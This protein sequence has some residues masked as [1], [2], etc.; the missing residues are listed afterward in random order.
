MKEEGVSL[1]TAVKL[2]DSSCKGPFQGIYGDSI[3]VYTVQGLLGCSGLV[4]S[5]VISPLIRLITVVTLLITPLRTA[6]EP[7]RRAQG[8]LK[9]VW[10]LGFRVVGLGV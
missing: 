4:I 1:W 10:G 7:P 3:R 6:H 2:R 5:R 8:N 9:T